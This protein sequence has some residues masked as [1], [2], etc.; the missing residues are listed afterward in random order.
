[1]IQPIMKDPI[2][3]A[4]PAADATPADKQT[5]Q[6]LLDTLVA[7]KGACVGMAANMIGVCKRIIAFECG[8]NDYMIM[9]NPE[10]VKM[11]QP[12]QAEE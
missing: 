11:S 4:Q 6:D 12:Y 8:E 5:A 10:I 9:Y 3:L 7:C 2:F 1:M